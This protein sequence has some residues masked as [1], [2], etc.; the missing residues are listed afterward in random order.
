[1]QLNARTMS[2]G[3]TDRIKEQKE[4]KAEARRQSAEAYK[5]KYEDMVKEEEEEQK[6][7]LQRLEQLVGE[8]TESPD[9]SEEA[10]PTFTRN[11]KRKKA[12]SPLYVPPDILY[13][14]EVVDAMTRNQVSAQELVE[15][16]S[17]IVSESGGKIENYYLN[18][19]NV[20]DQCGNTALNTAKVEKEKWS[21]PNPLVLMWDEKKMDKD[22]QDQIR[23]P[24]LAAGDDRPPHMLGSFKIPNGKAASIR[25]T[26]MKETKSW[27]IGKDEGEAKPCLTVWDTTKTNSGN[28]SHLDEGEKNCHLRPF[29]ILK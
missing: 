28:F 1:M 11:A 14:K 7:A 25:D 18:S 8:E 20:R 22:G 15:I 21:P 17:A 16:F 23:M 26:V 2:L 5:R 12:I 10:D 13:K 19:D 4:K 24:I 6:N 29:N 3:G 9:E 27:G